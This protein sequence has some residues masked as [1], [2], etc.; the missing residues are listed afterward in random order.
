MTF[1]GYKY[2]NGTTIDEYDPGKWQYG[3][4]VCI[5]VVSIAVLAELV[6]FL[7]AI[8]FMIRGIILMLIESM[9]APKTSSDTSA[10][11]LSKTFVSYKNGIFFTFSDKENH[12]NVPNP[13]ASHSKIDK[14][15]KRLSKGPEEPRKLSLEPK[16][17]KKKR[18]RHHEGKNQ[19]DERGSS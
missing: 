9:T 2:G 7:A 3:Q 4:N 18:A 16:L 17:E 1:K 11:K 13:P 10:E 5:L 8:F 12:S 14:K 19:T 15:H 6:I